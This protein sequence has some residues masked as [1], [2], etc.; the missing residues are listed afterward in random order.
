MVRV[1][2]DSATKDVQIVCCTHF[3]KQNFRICHG[4]DGTLL[5]NVHNP[6]IHVHNSGGQEWAKWAVLGAGG[7][8]RRRL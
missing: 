1:N 4:A 8:V 5:C 6:G 7:W 3:E 2:S